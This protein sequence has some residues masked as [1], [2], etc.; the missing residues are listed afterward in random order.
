M[1]VWLE[2]YVVHGRH[3]A[4]IFFGAVL[5]FIGLCMRIIFRPQRIWLEEKSNGCAVRVIGKNV[6]S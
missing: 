5:I 4:V 2:I 6:F 1:G 3:M